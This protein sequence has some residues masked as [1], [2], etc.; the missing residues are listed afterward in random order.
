[1][2][3]VSQVEAHGGH[4]DEDPVLLAEFPELEAID[5]GLISTDTGDMDDIDRFDLIRLDG[6]DERRQAWTLFPAFRAANPKVATLDE[7]CLSR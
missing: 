4:D 7:I 1:M 3:R 5:E 6:V 2:H